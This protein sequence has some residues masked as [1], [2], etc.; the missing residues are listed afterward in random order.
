M[1]KTRLGIV[2]SHGTNGKWLTVDM[3][4]PPTSEDLKSPILWMT[5][6]HAMAEAAQIVLRNKPELGPLPIFVKG[7][8][9]CLYC[10][11]GL[12]LVG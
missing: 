12:M 6:A 5:Q 4:K 10:V 2:R 7:V 8:C 1:V 11:V 9:D 3:S